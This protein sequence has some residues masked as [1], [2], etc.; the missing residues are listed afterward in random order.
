MQRNIDMTMKTYEFLHFANFK[1]I[2]NWSVQYADEVDLGFTNKYPM[3]RIGSFLHKSRDIIEIQDN[4]EYKQV[5]IKINNGGVVPRNNGATLKGS[6]IG[7]K[8]QYVVHTGQ[9]IMSRIDARNGAYGIVPEELEGAIVTSD[10]PVFFVDTCRIIP[11]FLVLVST[12]DKFIEFARKC[13]SGTTN[14]KRIDIETFLQQQIPLP[15]IE[16]QG[17]IL[18]EYNE[19]V[20]FAKRK[21][22]EINA[23]EDDSKHFVHSKLG[24]KQKDTKQKESL[25]QFIHFKNITTRWDAFVETY[26]MECNYRID[27]LGDYIMHISTG[28]TPPTSHPE[29]FDGDI[30]FFTPADLGKDKYLNGSESTRKISEKAIV[31]K[32]ARVFKKG[33][34]LFVGIGSTVGKVGIVKDD[35]VSSNQQ[36]TGFTVDCFR[37]NPEYLYYY[38]LYNR[39]I[40]TAEQ[41]KTTLPIVNQEKIC[42]I[43]VVV[44]PL[45]IQKEIVTTL[46]KMYLTAKQ[47]EKEIPLL[48]K[49]A[50][51]NFE[52]IIFDKL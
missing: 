45:D 6:K 15:N 28:T 8:R 25:L 41:S 26:S 32:K 50:F 19:C 34:I 49:K 51:S 10:F 14:R 47:N 30:K 48:Q 22:V 17:K 16:E 18:K 39:D 12:T 24:I 52:H 35:I 44:P 5:T 9:F 27:P 36:I 43:P 42:K 31:D 11:Q 1:D 21:Q 40:T 29:Y 38:L 7:T 46:D 20:E 3:A 23:L 2:P 37:I 4:V 33:D 13:S